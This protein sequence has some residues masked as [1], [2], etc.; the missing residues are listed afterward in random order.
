VFSLREGEIIRLADLEQQ[1]R[2]IMRKLTQVEPGQIDVFI[3][4]MPYNP[5]KADF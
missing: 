4:V 5:E 3:D 2:E 1:H